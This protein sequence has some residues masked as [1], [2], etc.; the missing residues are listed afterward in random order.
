MNQYIKDNVDDL[1]LYI[2]W[3]YETTTYVY[4]N[5]QWRLSIPY[6]YTNGK[7]RQSMVYKHTNNKWR[8]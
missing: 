8:L 1:K 4:T 3:Q 2:L 7:Y 6:V 5:G